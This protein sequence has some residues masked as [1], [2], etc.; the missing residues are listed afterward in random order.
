MYLY[1]SV[2]YKPL[3]HYFCNVEGHFRRAVDAIK[4][5][6]GRKVQTL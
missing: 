2:G 4:G 5:R 6:K 3:V 1:Y